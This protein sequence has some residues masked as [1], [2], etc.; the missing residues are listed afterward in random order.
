MQGDA[1]IVLLHADAVMIGENAIR[2]DPALEGFQQHHLQVAA[3][4]RKLRM[5]VAGPAAERLL[6]DQLAEA[7]EEGCIFGLDRHPRQI[8]FKA[9]RGEFLGGVRQEVDA[10][11]YRADFRR[12]LEDATGHVGRVQR[13]TQG[14]AANAATDDQDVVH[15]SS[16]IAW[17]CGCRDET[18]LVSLLSIGRGTAEPM[19]YRLPTKHMPMREASLMT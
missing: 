7:V 18:R 6:I 8:R 1:V 4:N 5:V 12:G 3:M 9:K 11:T 10:D 19:F 15:V 17:L 13:Q 16:R 14:Q 2:A